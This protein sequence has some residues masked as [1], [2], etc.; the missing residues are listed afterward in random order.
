MSV[1]FRMSMR[2]EKVDHYYRK[3]NECLQDIR[4]P[5]PRKDKLSKRMHGAKIFSKFDVKLGF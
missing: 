3:L 2:K 5:V 1:T 4:Y